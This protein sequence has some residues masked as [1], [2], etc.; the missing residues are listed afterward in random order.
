MSKKYYVKKTDRPKCYPQSE[1]DKWME[2]V[3]RTSAGQ[4]AIKFNVNYQTVRNEMKR[5]GIPA[6]A[7]G[8]PRQ[9][10]DE[11]VAKI[12]AHYSTS[13]SSE[14]TGR[15]FGVSSSSVLLFARK[16][17]SVKSLPIAA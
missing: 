6:L 16:Q 4:A 15:A 8:N 10:D 17:R 11:T 5:R 3:K 9:I 7:N 2:E 14:L 1:K 13:R 12:L